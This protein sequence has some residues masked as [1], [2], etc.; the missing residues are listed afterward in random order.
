M[1]NKLIIATLCT[2]LLAGC[3]EGD[4]QPEVQGKG[5][6]QY[7]KNVLA[8]GERV[9]LTN[10]AVCHGNGGEGKPGWQQPGPDGKLLPPPLDGN[11]RV[12]RLT[13]SQ[14]KQF[15]H[16]GSP[17]GRA[18]MPAWQG[19]LSDQEIDEVITWITSLWSDAIYLQWVTKV[20]QAQN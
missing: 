20:G 6:R 14:M 16:Q 5:L 15:V 19:K 4:K 10:C 17:D 12:W 3:G 9:F 7:D 2:A 18:N 11:G 13:S 8:R 1:N